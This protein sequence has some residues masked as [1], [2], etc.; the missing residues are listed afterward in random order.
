[1]AKKQEFSLE[2]VKKYYFWVV[3]PIGLVA[4]IFVTMGAVGKITAE[5]NARKQ[6][7]E[8]TKK[9]VEGIRSEK[10]HPNQKTIDEIVNKTSELGDRVISAWKILEKDQRER[11]LWPEE[12]GESF[13]AEVQK[14]KFGSEISV[15]SREK[16]LN[17][18]NEYLPYLERFV[19]RRR[20]QEKVK[21]E[22][23]E[24][25]PQSSMANQGGVPGAISDGILSADVNLPRGPD[26]EEL[27]RYVGIVDW[28]NPETRTVTTHWMKLPKAVEIWYAQ[29]ELWVYAALLSVIKETNTGATGPHNAVVKR[30]ENLSIGKLA[31]TGLAARS[32][33]RIGIGGAGGGDLSAGGEMGMSASPMT[34]MASGGDGSQIVALTEAQ[35]E[36]FI[37][38][39]RY[40]DQN[41]QPLAASAAAP[42]NEFNR[43][44]ICLRLI[45]DQRR[46]P[47]I[48]VNCANCAMP[49]EV[50]WVRIN[51]GATRPF[52]LSAYVGSGIV[53][54]EVTSEMGTVN[55]S[56]PGGISGA[57]SAP[58]Q[59]GGTLGAYGSE[60]IP[61]EIYGWINIFNSVEE[62][63][64]LKKETSQ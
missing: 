35:A 20:L 48:L 53:S 42:F 25:A 49:I 45:V 59:L 29:E 39:N 61:I 23:V 2:T 55:A 57:E 10:N 63:T 43:M 18:I 27:Y 1:M 54:G 17:F 15:D 3:V 22:W 5:F 11:N 14:L 13:L 6:T 40:V 41:A 37:R 64:N 9:N 47:E 30:I 4:A 16:Y 8:S 50:L 56:A 60:A 24:I 62:S 12:V 21:D 46:I 28:P 7:L 32:A 44:P 31:S 33:L 52:E 58:M 38:G 19:E 36:E 51:P 26:G 34:D